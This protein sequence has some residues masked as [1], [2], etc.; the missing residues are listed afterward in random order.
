MKPKPIAAVLALVLAHSAAAAA[1]LTGMR[2]TSLGKDA[3]ALHVE[4]S[5]PATASVTW[6]EEPGAWQSTSASP[7]PAASH[8]LRMPG[9]AP[10]RRYFY[11][12]LVDGEPAG[13]LATFVSGR[14]W[15]TRRAVILATAA[16]PAPTPEDKALADRLFAKE[17]DALVLLSGEGDAPAFRA[18]YARAMADRVVVTGPASPSRTL[19]VSDV[20]M[21]FGDLDRS[22]RTEGS[23][24]RVALDDAAAPGA[25]VALRRGEASSIAKEAGGI[26]VTLAGRSHAI[27]EAAE[28]RLT[29]TLVDGPRVA[30]ESLERACA[31]PVA[32]A[33]AQG[34]APYDGDGDQLSLDAEP[35]DAGCDTP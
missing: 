4:L 3:A 17:A 5:E 28:G 21:G 22:A 15:V 29:V 24:W 35:H 33:S 31:V 34:E 14:S 25:D 30:S 9:L 11:Q 13:D 20:V 27:V 2:L 16:A 18:H 6:G 8:D 7:G 32:E 12:V 1:T 19:A 26:T 23:C 10:D